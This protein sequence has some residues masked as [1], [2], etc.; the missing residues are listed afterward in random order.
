MLLGFALVTLG[1]CFGGKGS[2]NENGDEE[3]RYNATDAKV[4]FKKVVGKYMYIPKRIEE[5]G[6]I[7]DDFKTFHLSRGDTLVLEIKPDSTFVFNHLCYNF[8]KTNL[9]DTNPEIRKL[10][11]YH[12]KVYFENI[13]PK[14]DSLSPHQ[15]LPAGIND[16]FLP[17]P[18]YAMNLQGFIET[19]S[20]LYFYTRLSFE[21]YSNY[22]YKLIYKKIK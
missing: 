8:D 18:D 12:G 19:K 3:D 1:S 10:D 2:D 15:M 6:Y 20:N 22:E 16:F 9:Y 17:L 5:H 7:F 4:E 21:H 11:N 13:H 14:K